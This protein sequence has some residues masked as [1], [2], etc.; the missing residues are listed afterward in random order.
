MRSAR[1]LIPVLTAMATTLAACGGDD[2]VTAS[3]SP[4]LDKNTTCVSLIAVPDN[5]RFDSFDD[6]L[7]DQYDR[8]LTWTQ[9]ASLQDFGPGKKVRLS[10]SFNPPLVVTYDHATMVFLMQMRGS[11]SVFNSY[12]FPVA[13]LDAGGGVST[14][15]A[16]VRIY[17]NSS[18]ADLWCGITCSFANLVT[19]QELKR[20]LVTF[21]VPDT[22]SSGTAAGDAIPT[23][24]LD[25]E[26]FYVQSRLA[27][28]QPG[29]AM[30][31]K[32]EPLP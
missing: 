12:A 9:A 27:A 25:I 18:T 15:G 23:G 7:Y 2:N 30:W 22:F 4:C 11:G 19:D 20:L 31:P 13:T 1:F 32:G 3:S 26:G 28:S 24:A 21:T 6:P 10:V 17:G 14:T 5:M 8:T 16:D 29:P